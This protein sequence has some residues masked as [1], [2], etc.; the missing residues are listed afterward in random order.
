MRILLLCTLLIVGF[1]NPHVQ[2]RTSADDP[3]AVRLGR[4]GAPPPADRGLLVPADRWT[5][6]QLP[7]RG[8]EETGLPPELLEEIRRQVSLIQ[9]QVDAE[10]WEAALRKTEGALNVYGD[11]SAFLFLAAM[12]NDE[13][14]ELVEAES[15]WRRLNQVRDGQWL[16]LQRWGENLIRQQRLDEARQAFERA[17]NAY[18]YHTRTMLFLALVELMA[19]RADVAARWVQRMSPVDLVLMA[20]WLLDIE[21]DQDWLLPT[22]YEQAGR[23][24]LRGGRALPAAVPA[25]TA[26]PPVAEGF[27]LLTDLAP[28]TR[29]AP[30]PQSVDLAPIRSRLQRMVRVT[31]RFGELLDAE[32]WSG[33]AA[34]AR[35]PRL[36]EIEFSAPS[37]QAFGL[38]AAHRAGDTDALD[39]LRSLS[40]AYPAHIHV[41][42][43]QAYVLLETGRHR[44]ATR[45]L[46]SLARAEPDHLLG[47]LLLATALAESDRP[48]DALETLDRIDPAYNGFIRHWLTTELDYNRQL[49]EN[50]RF[51]PWRQSLE[52]P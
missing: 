15:Y 30:T 31:K 4:T 17:L 42:L 19:D 48:A 39:Q 9:A 29:G 22:V 41:Q 20:Q 49:R 51:E 47:P 2:A 32:Q 3:F 13:L 23:L 8:E 36:E 10:N 25:A 26:A 44:E 50:P 14:D 52:N 12:I 21:E 5:P 11:L 1:S 27:L 24:V 40:G 6:D 18:A 28:P 43:R 33:A 38:Y 7:E 16:L 37:F 35:H 45:L 34:L 46:T